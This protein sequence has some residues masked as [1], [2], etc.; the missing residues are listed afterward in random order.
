MDHEECQ[1]EYLQR[2]HAVEDY[3]E[4]H[5][6]DTPDLHTL[7]AL[8]GFSKFHFHR[9]FKAITG[10]TPL[11][12]MHRIKL[13]RAAAYLQH[14]PHVAVTNVALHYGFTDSSVYSRAFKAH[15][16]QSP[17]AFRRDKR[18]NCKDNNSSPA[19]TQDIQNLEIRRDT[20]HTEAKSVEQKY[21]DLKVI[22]IRHTGSYQELSAAIPPALQ[23][24][25]EFAMQAQLLDP[26]QT[27]I[28]SA[29]HDSPDMTDETKLRTSICLSIRPDAKVAASGDIGEMR[30][31]G[32]YAIG[33][34]ELPMHAYG[35]AWEYMYSQWLP[36]SGMQPRDTFPFEVYVSDP[37][38]N[39][40]GKQLLDICIPIEPLGQI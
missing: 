36:D 40:G 37:S 30:L 1:N 8:A 20:M 10:E 31:Q 9:I 6:E 26:Q 35:L 27:S 28:L 4:T 34:F 25:Y 14:T 12:Y 21:L 15:F 22:Y 38:Q 2:V 11:A 17:T 13:V 29:Y 33:H 32:E 19:Y 24:L 39:P 16:G 18:K 23:K 3:I 7:A 5:P